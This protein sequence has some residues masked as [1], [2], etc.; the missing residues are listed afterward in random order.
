LRLPQNAAGN[1]KGTSEASIE[2]RD[3]KQLSCVDRDQPMKGYRW[4]AESTHAHDAFGQ[5]DRTMERPACNWILASRRLTTS[6]TG[7][8]RFQCRRATAEVAERTDRPLARAVDAA[9][10]RGGF[11][12]LPQDAFQQVL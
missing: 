12:I 6:G 8:V 4:S 9:Q 7:L 11:Q 2:R 5:R 10:Q 3:A 1:G